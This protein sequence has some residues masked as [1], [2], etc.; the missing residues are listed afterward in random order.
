[1]S[2]AV[3][4]FAREA[5]VDEIVVRSHLLRGY[6]SA[7]IELIHSPHQSAARA[8]GDAIEAGVRRHYRKYGVLPCGEPLRVCSGKSQQSVE[9]YQK[10]VWRSFQF[11]TGTDGDALIQGGGRQNDPF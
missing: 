11:E 3:A 2:R 5:G 1:M 9:A 6:S 7:D 8:A 10:D 4:Q